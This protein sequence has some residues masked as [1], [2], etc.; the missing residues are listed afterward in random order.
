MRIAGRYT[1]S[2]TG[3]HIPATR[4][5][6][7]PLTMNSNPS[8]RLAPQLLSARVL[9]TALVV[10][11]SSVALLLAGCSLGTHG[12]TPHFAAKA[13]AICRR[14]AVAIEALPVPNDVPASEARVTRDDA[15]YAAAELRQLEHL[16]P[17]KRAGHTYGQALGAVDQ[18]VTL[19]RREAF[20]YAHGKLIQAESLINHGDALVAVADAAMTRLNLGDCAANP[21]PSAA[22]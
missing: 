1:E 21:Q 8:P 20:D 9:A 14:A 19:D 10:L 17:S 3:E 7:Q 6:R 4:V 12:P 22:A 18:I 5:A 13:S 16:T 2:S 11:P 15:N